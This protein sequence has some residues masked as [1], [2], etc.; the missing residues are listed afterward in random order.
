[1]VVG[2]LAHHAQAL[3]V[4]DV[5]AAGSLEQRLDDD[6]GELVGVRRGQR[7]EPRGPRGH[8]LGD[9]RRSVGEHLRPA[10]HR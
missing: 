6:P 10:V 1:M 5:H 9:S 7:P 8:V 4:V 3:G 2:H